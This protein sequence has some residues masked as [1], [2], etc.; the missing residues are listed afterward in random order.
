[1]CCDGK[2]DALALY[3]GGDLPENERAAIEAH[4]KVCGPCR[5]YL[6]E[7]TALCATLR[8]FNGTTLDGL[9]LDALHARIYAATS[10]KKRRR[11]TIQRALVAAGLAACVLLTVAVTLMLGDRA[12]EPAPIS[13]EG[14]MGMAASP[15]ADKPTIAVAATPEQ[16]KMDRVVAKILTRD[17]NIVIILLASD[18]TG[19]KSDEADA[20]VL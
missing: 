17:P 16:P 19:E 4:I 7:L 2:E 20:S 3:A 18:D 15:V 12:V 9:A 6:D 13:V 10:Q 11:M 8:R 14:T 5:V 1:M